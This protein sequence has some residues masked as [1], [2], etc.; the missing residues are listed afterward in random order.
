[1][2]KYWLPNADIVSNFMYQQ[3]YGKWVTHRDNTK[4]LVFYN[5]PD[6]VRIV[7]GL[8]RSIIAHNTNH[9]C[10]MVTWDDKEHNYCV[11][12]LHYLPETHQ[13]KRERS[14]KDPAWSNRWYKGGQEY[15]SNGINDRAVRANHPTNWLDSRD[16]WD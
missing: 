5:E 4:E 7:H 15:T 1:M 14:K 8:R 3:G 10:I 13:R 16:R 12:E 2:A 9:K 11:E 6:I